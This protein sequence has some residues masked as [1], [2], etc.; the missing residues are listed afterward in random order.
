MAGPAAPI[1]A[2]ATALGAALLYVTYNKGTTPGGLASVGS[3]SVR[4]NP[5]LSTRTVSYRRNKDVSVPYGEEQRIQPLGRIGCSLGVQLGHCGDGPLKVPPNRA[6]R[7]KWKNMIAGYSDSTP[8]IC[9]S[10]AS[11]PRFYVSLSVFHDYA[12]SLFMQY[13][14]GPAMCPL[15][16]CICIQFR[17]KR[18][19]SCS[20]V[21][22]VDA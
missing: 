3:S 4:T 13:V 15:F 11:E 19:S 5:E 21:S 2:A 22:I 16:L 7:T 17:R 10:D 20:A 8:R 12:I 14:F 18:R 9:F 6:T 1:V